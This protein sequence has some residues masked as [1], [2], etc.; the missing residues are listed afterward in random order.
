MGDIRSL[1]DNLDKEERGRVILQLH[2]R[3][4]GNGEGWLG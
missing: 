4:G 1:I 3:H 2:E